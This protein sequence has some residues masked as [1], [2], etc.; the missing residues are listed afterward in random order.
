MIDLDNPYWLQWYE[1][2]SGLDVTQNINT[3]DKVMREKLSP[4]VIDFVVDD[5]IQNTVIAGAWALSKELAQSNL[6]GQ[7]GK[8]ARVTGKIGM[9]AVPLVGWGLLA[10]D[11]YQVGS[12]LYEEYID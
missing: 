6:P 10:Y 5:T 12:W 4:S 2:I 8:Y 11:A 9:R 1:N 3:S 7:L